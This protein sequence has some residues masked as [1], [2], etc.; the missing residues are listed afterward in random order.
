MDQGFPSRE[1]GD[2]VGWR[3]GKEGWL[4]GTG[5][6]SSLMRPWSLPDQFHPGLSPLQCAS[7]GGCTP[8]ETTGM[9]SRGKAPGAKGSATRIQYRRATPAPVTGETVKYVLCFPTSK[10]SK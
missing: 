6:S 10:H 1:D 4:E 7:R 9:P 3:G 8:E 5:A 2:L